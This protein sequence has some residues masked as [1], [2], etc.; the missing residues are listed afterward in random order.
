MHR[1]SA[2]LPQNI[3]QKS[4]C[5]T[6]RYYNRVL[7]QGIVNIVVNIKIHVFMQGRGF[8]SGIS[9]AE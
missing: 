4:L 8:A 1:A 6:T 5:I 7:Q 2:A 9:H 3:L